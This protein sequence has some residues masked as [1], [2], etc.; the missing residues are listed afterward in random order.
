MA[1]KEEGSK[2]E[3]ALIYVFFEIMTLILRPKVQRAAPGLP[4]ERRANQAP[5]EQLIL[6]HYT[7]SLLPSLVFITFGNLGHPE[8]QNIFR[9]FITGWVEHLK[10]C[11]LSER[12]GFGGGA[13]SRSAGDPAAL[14]SRTSNLT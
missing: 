1:E 10:K 4:Q 7:S 2:E 9:S 11:F 12:A 14:K 6:H 5:M 13:S 8:P 3:E